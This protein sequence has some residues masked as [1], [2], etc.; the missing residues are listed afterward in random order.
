MTNDSPHAISLNQTAQ[1]AI[2]SFQPTDVNF[3]SVPVNTT[4]TGD[5]SVI[6]NS[7]N[8]SAHTSP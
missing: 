1:G 2:L 4:S 3:G 5:F 6:V 7:G 8:V